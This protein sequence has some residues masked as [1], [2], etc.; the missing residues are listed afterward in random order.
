M[1]GTVRPWWNRFQEIVTAVEPAISSDTA[2]TLLSAL[3][4]QGSVGAVHRV[5]RVVVALWLICAN[6]GLLGD[7]PT[8]AQAL[9]LVVPPQCQAS[10]PDLNLADGAAALT[11]AHEHSLVDMLPYMLDVHGEGTR[12]SVMKDPSNRHHR[13]ARKRAGSYLTPSDAVSY[14]VGRVLPARCTGSE[15]LLDPACGTGVFLQASLR[16]LS[17]RGFKG[18]SGIS[19]L[20][21][22]D[23]SPAAVDACR[24]VLLAEGLRIEKGAD[25]RVLWAELGRQLAVGDSLN[26]VS[27]AAGQHG[28]LWESEQWPAGWPSS[29]TAL[30]GNPPY[31]PLG[32]RAD[33]HQLGQTFATMRKAT[34]ATN[35]YLP[36]AEM[37]W[38]LLSD[39]GQACMVVPMS[40][41]Y[42]STEAMRSLRAA[43]SNAEGAW[44]FAF[45][46]RTPDALFGD[47]VKQRVAIVSFRR[48]TVKEVRTGPVLR[49][50]SRTRSR[51]FDDTK[52]VSLGRVDMRG[53]VPKI[54]CELERSAYQAIRALPRRLQD[55]TA[56]RR[57]ALDE[58]KSSERSVLVAGTAYNW[59]TAYRSTEWARDVA[60][61]SSSPLTLLACT[62]NRL[63]DATYALTSS[64]L[65]YWLWRADGDCFHVPLAFLAELPALSLMTEERIG[66]LATVGKQLWLKAGQTP[67]RSVN[68]GNATVTFSP[69]TQWN[70]VKTIDEL[71]VDGLGLPPGLESVLADLV[72]RNIVVDP[73]DQVRVGR[74]NR[75]HERRNV[76]Q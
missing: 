26:L 62:S 51:L 61:P 9:R 34:R 16:L 14:M 69:W 42:S 31:A 55:E 1:T 18:S 64:K 7:S 39:E 29:F 52:S 41:A 45:F 60:S 12:L 58:A 67:I 2:A 44:E 22:I 23:V 5:S 25:P 53:G 28:P 15:S 56:L 27:A 66:D 33:L 50:T 30:V 20:F 54:G 47:D 76:W 48:Q 36:F 3:G 75:P 17:E 74:G 73:S 37:M 72:E 21:G 71:L 38:L 35:A 8:I 63:A 59:L 10:V 24:A 40:I 65:T 43:M 70:L 6:R 19:A 46:D 11:L 4:L 68:R 49:W 57:M 32:P 13:T